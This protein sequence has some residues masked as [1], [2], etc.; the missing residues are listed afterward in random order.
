[1]TYLAKH[2]TLF[3]LLRFV[4]GCNYYDLTII[5]VVEK[6]KFGEGE[7]NIIYGYIIHLIVWQ[8]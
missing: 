1:M 8:T 5:C 4:V 7:K 3:I 2:Q 6:T